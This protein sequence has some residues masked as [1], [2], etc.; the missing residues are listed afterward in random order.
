MENFEWRWH[1]QDG[2][3]FFSRGWSPEAAPKAVLCLVHGMGEHTNRY[4]H[5][6]SALAEAGYAV[7]GFDLR[8]HG[9]SEG[10]RGHIP[11]FE[12]CLNDISEFQKQLDLRYPNLPKVLYGHSL[13]GNLAANYLLRVKS[14]FQAAI[15]T[16][17]YFRL[18]FE[19]PAAKIALGRMMS[20]ISPKFSQETGLETAALSRDPQ[21]VRAYV[22]DPLVH[23][24]ISA[25]MFI[26]VME[27]GEWA[28]EHAAELAVPMLL[29]HGSADRLTSA[30]ASQ[31]FA[32][33]AGE[34]VTLVLWEGFYHEIHN[35][36]E[37][38]EVFK[39]MIAWLDAQVAA[40]KRA[41]HP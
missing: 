32:R 40:L 29:M 16:G 3:E 4:G 30:S 39:T 9:L 14:A 15:I 8:G 21:V 12:H 17:P 26:S 33:R 24:L 19:P 31:E 23:D 2:L 38:A 37:P 22:T 28:L 13:G 11:S 10:Q 7:F 6:A 5:V 36:P 34:K 25:R 27:A 18:A 20:N 35:E 1:A 41:P